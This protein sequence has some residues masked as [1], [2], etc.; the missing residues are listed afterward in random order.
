MKPCPWCYSKGYV[1]VSVVS[2]ETLGEYTDRK[3]CDDCHGY[4]V[5]LCES[6]LDEYRRMEE[7]TSN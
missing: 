5:I 6:D 3:L 7:V 1:C 2:L 4:G